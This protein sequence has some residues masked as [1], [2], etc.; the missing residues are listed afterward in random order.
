MTTAAAYGSSW[1]G[2]GIRAAAEAYPTAIATLDLS[3]ICDL[4]CSL[5]QCNAGSLTHRARPEME[6]ALHRD[7]VRS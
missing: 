3:R 7:T 1:A 2:G 4:C 5:W 6:T